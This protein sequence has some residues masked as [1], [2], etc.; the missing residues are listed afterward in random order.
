MPYPRSRLLVVDAA[1]AGSSKHL[2]HGLIEIDVTQARSRLRAHRE[3]TGE[4]LSFTAFFLRSLGTAVSENP[5]VHAYRDWR[6]RL[7]LFDD[8]DVNT[9]V[10]VELDGHRFPLAHTMRAVNRR[11]LRDLHEEI[12][13]VQASGERSYGRNTQDVA[14]LYLRLPG[15]I[16]GLVFYAIMR[17]PHW[18]KRIA[19]TVG[20]TAVGMFGNG[21]G[22]GIP[23]PVYT[24]TA[25]LGGIAEKP[26]VFEGEI[27]AREMLSIT[28][29]FDHDILDG[30][31]AARFAD[32]LKQLVEAGY[33]LDGA[34]G[35]DS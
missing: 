8:V 3:R 11:P 6:G 31:P 27:V 17:N 13:A 9:I 28:L 5:I 12:R 34:L 21:A 26:A 33:G 18:M 16:R 30:A 20:V 4:T 23:L 29:T 2:I 14:R 32:R 25:T 7:I 35:T 24:M 1:R 19:G 10:E 15:F 22:W